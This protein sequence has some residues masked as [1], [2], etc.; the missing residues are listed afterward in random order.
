MRVGIQ[1]AYKYYIQGAHKLS[2]DFCK[3]V[4]SQI[5]NR[6][7]WCYYHLKEE[8]LQFHSDL[9]W[10]RC[11]SLLWRGRCPGDTPIP[12]KPSQACLVWRSRLRCWCALAIMVVSLE[13]VGRKHCPWRNPTGRNH[14][15]SCLV[16]GVARR[17]RCCLCPLHD[18]SIDLAGVHS[19]TPGP[20]Y[21]NVVGPRLV[22]TWPP[23]S[24]DLTVCDFF[25]WGF[26]KDEIPDG[27]SNGIWWKTCTVEVLH[28]EIG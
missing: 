7:T 3:T 14:T 4:F 16:T 11:A 1:G 9:K 6:N 19:G 25:L 18:Q 17:R 10:I 20:P 27:I 22:G 21:A 2:E 26:V 28:P 13:V 15:L 24:P 23:R 5:L 12:A 8:C